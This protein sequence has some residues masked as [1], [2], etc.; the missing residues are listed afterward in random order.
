MKM[1]KKAEKVTLLL[2]QVKKLQFVKIVKK[3]LT[4]FEMIY[5]ENKLKKIYTVKGA[6]NT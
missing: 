1:K 6:S 3:K 5:Q 2:F 4:S